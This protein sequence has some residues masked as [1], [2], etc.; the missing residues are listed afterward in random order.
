MDDEEDKHDVRLILKYI[1]DEVERRLQLKLKA[2]GF[3]TQRG[4]EGLNAP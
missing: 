3:K 4:K 2:G 1:E